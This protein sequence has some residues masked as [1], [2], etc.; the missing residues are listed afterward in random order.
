MSLKRL[1]ISSSLLLLLAEPLT[2]IRTA[3]AYIYDSL[4][5]EKKQIKMA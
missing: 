5:V 3:G 1:L 4:I 2:L